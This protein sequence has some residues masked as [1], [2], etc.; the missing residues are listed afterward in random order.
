MD[1]FAVFELVGGLAMFLYGMNVMGDGLEKQAGGKLKTILEKMTS[2]PVKGFLLGLAVTAVIQSSSATTVMVVGFVNAGIMKLRQAIGIIMGA[3]VGTT[4][5]AWILSLTGLEGD[6]FIV[7]I[8]KP[9][10]FSPLVAFIGIVMIMFFKKES[11]RNIGSIAMGFAVLMFGMDMMSAAVKPLQN[12]PEFTSILT[13]FSNPILGVLAGALL[14]AVIQSSSASVGILQ[15]LS[16]TGS[17]TFSSAVP[18]ILGQNIGTCVTALLSSVGTNKNARRAAVVHLYFNLIG[19]TLFLVL[20]YAAHAILDFSFFSLPIDRMGI[21][22]VHTLFNL[23]ST[24][25]LLPFAGLLEKLALLTI[26]DDGKD[27]KRKVLDEDLLDERFLASPSVAIFQSQKMTRSM[28]TLAQSCLHQA[29]SLIGNYDEQ[30]AHAIEEGEDQIDLY[31]DKLGS[32]LVHL[33]GKSLT[34][35]E[36]HEVSKLLH[37]IGDFERIGDHAVNILKS[38]KEM[39]DKKFVFSDDAKKELDTISSAIEEVVHL[40]T[41]AF[42]RDDLAMASQVEPLEQVVDNMKNELRARHISRLQAGECTIHNGFVFSD[43]ITNYERVADHCSNIG[44]C[45]LRIAEDTFDTHEYLNHIKDG[46]NDSFEKNYQK[47]K[48]KYSLV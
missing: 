16:D 24:L 7:Q 41:E 26:R 8:L 31:E 42:I 34:L 40:A 46:H 29:I 30:V 44:V 28:A 14:T 25:T 45:L 23:V 35:Q 39:K 17:V 1:I 6:S 11:L 12:V 20:F 15:A 38:A 43:L 48:E 13:M 2:N 27:E 32:Y 18:I 4:V 10:T 37:V 36:S 21:S 22:V 9:S 33:S 47:Y 3:N 19:T 5:T